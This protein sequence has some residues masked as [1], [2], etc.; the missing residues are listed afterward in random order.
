MTF[1]ALGDVLLGKHQ[2]IDDGAGIGPGAEQVI[3]LEET[4]VPV[5]GMSDHQG[6]HAHG[7][8]FH[9]VGDAGVGVDDDF[10]GKPHLP[11]AVG[12]LGTEELFAV[13][14]VVITQRHADRGVGIHHLLG[15]DHLDL[16]GV[17]VQGVTFGQAADFPVVGPDQVERPL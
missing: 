5:A 6:L 10:V 8:L 17:G 15:G 12:F 9:E 7:V 13:G 11:A 14:P 1:L 3:A 2:V 16:V 4:V